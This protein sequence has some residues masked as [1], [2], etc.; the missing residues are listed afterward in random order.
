MNDR[1]LIKKISSLKSINADSSWKK[2]TRDILL[3]QA[4]NSTSLNVKMSWIE[5]CLAD[6]KNLFSFMPASAWGVACMIFI[7]VAGSF[8]FIGVRNSKPGDTLYN[9]KMLKDKVQLAI[10]FDQEDKAKLDMKLASMHAI[11]IADVLSDPDSNIANDPK[12]SEELA[13]NFTKEINT[14]KERYSEINKLQN[15]STSLGVSASGT[16]TL[17]GLSDDGKVGIGGIEK[18]SSS[19]KVYSVGAGKDDK[20]LQIYDSKDKTILSLSSASSSNIAVAGTSTAITVTQNSSSTTENI[21]TTLDKASQS[22]ASKDFSET[23]NILNQVGQI[24]DN[25]SGSVKG[26]EE[27]GTST[28]GNSQTE[29]ASTS[30]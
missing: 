12:K 3:A 25:I 20:G 4:S 11:E 24:I 22:F 18:D 2:E 16:K 13:Q 23:K 15:S 7:L 9:A 17:A 26:A 8:G 19:S 27:S 10:T 1:E 30:K 6:I 28:S 5:I 21:N 29:A 14:V